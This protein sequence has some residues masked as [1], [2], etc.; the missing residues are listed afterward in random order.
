MGKSTD[1]YI[2][3]E[4]PATCTTKEKRTYKS[5]SKLNEIYIDKL[6]KQNEYLS[7]MTISSVPHSW[8]CDIVEMMAIW[9]SITSI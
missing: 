8:C 7:V 4:V 5:L 2:E 9:Y 1:S 6:L 3:T